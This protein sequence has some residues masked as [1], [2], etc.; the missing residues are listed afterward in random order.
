MGTADRRPG[1]PPPLDG[2]PAR[3]VLLMACPDPGSAV[4]PTP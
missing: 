3:K 2:R 1:T 4:E